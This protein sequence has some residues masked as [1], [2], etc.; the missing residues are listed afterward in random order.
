MIDP[1]R[2]FNLFNKAEEGTSLK[3]KEEIVDQLIS[4]RDTPAF[5]LGVFKKLILNHTNFNVNL[6]NMLKRAN[7]ELDIDDMQN[8]SEFIIYTR[9]WEYIKDLN[10]KDITVFE[11]LKMGASEELVITLA[12]A[13]DFFEQNE[14]YEKCAHLKK[15]SDITQY[16]LK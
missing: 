3:E 6:L 12:L 7:D 13:I 8:A 15:I 11:A 5:K 10:A 9:A 4:M 14:D 16:F 2:I 1:E